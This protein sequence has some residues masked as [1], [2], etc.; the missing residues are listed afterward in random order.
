MTFFGLFKNNMVPRID[1]VWINHEA[2][3]KGCFELIQQQ[4]FDI[5]IAWFEETSDLFRKSIKEKYDRDVEPVLAQSIYSGSLQGKKILFLEHYPIFSKEQNL[6]ADKGIQ[7]LCFVNSLEDPVLSMF[8]T[9]IGQLMRTMGLDE[10]ECLEHKLISK[11]IVNAQK[12][13]EKKLR[14]DFNAKSGEDWIR[15]Y[16]S[17]TKAKF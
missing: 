6:L 3:I 15:Q 7:K 16:T 2:K 17:M 4:A 8:S 14:R 11:S 1:L 10:K 13:I 12:K 5:I 9:N